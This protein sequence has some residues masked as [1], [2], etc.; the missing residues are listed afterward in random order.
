[1]GKT[2]EGRM[3][4]SIEDKEDAVEELMFSVGLG[5]EY[6][7]PYTEIIK[8]HAEFKRQEELDKLRG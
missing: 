4:I 7:H 1:M 8:E 2:S 6:N 3:P 5:D